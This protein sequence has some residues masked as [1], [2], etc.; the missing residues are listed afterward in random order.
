MPSFRILC[1][2]CLVLIAL[3]S[4]FGILI[5]QT[6]TRVKLAPKSPVPNSL[7]AVDEAQ[8]WRWRRYLHTAMY[9]DVEIEADTVQVGRVVVVSFAVFLDFFLRLFLYFGRQ[10]VH[11]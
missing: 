4:V 5:I 2:S 9:T 8:L 3:C 6:D 10:A 11:T 7:P 1:V